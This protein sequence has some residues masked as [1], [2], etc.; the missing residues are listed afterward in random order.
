[1]LYA[2]IQVSTDDIGNERT[3]FLIGVTLLIRDRYDNFLEILD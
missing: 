2:M 1:M 3:C